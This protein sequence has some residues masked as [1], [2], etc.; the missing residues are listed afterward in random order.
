MNI[1]ELSERNYAQ[2][3]KKVVK[4]NKVWY[5]NKDGGSAVSP[6]TNRDLVVYPFWSDSF[7][8][9]VCA[10]NEW[11]GYKPKAIPLTEFLEVWL[12]PLYQDRRLIG[13]NWNEELLGKEMNP[14]ELLLA[15]IKEIN[16]KNVEHQLKLL[17]Y[18]DLAD[19]EHL[20]KDLLE[21]A[22]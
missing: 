12:I 16:R 22:S 13:T 19:L 2:F 8:A 3:I 11:E 17:M 7:Y 9:K 6:S 4:Q 14:A 21:G 5:L 20:A 15:L 10:N 18:D 1:Q